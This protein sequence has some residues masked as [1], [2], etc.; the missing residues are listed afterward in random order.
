MTFV[1]QTITGFTHQPL[2]IQ[3]ELVFRLAELIDVPSSAPIKPG[4]YGGR[5][6]KTPGVVGGSARINNRRITVWGIIERYRLG[7]TDK[8]LLESYPFLTPTD[9]AA[10]KAY[11]DDYRQEIDLEIAINNA[12]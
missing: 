5:I 3:R 7:Q 4:S 12:V 8:E 9:L 2:E 1:E 10:A 11:Y 6:V